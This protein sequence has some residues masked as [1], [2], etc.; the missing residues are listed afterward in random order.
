MDFEVI[1]STIIA[2]GIGTIG[3]AFMIKNLISTGIQKSIELNFNK[4]LETYKSTLSKELENLKSTL[5]NSEVYFVRQLEA[6]SVLRSLFRKILPV[7]QFPDGDWDE[8]LESIVDNFETHRDVLHDYL[9]TYEAVLPTDVRNNL[10]MAYHLVADIRF[11]FE[12]HPDTHEVVPL[13]G[14][15][16]NANSFHEQIRESINRFQH[17]IERQLGHKL[18]STPSGISDS[19]SA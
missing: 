9:C 13:R 18:A 1:S 8:A 14:A 15:M 10:G 6:L 19:D 2:S 3:A 12:S 11:E 4:H 5:K 7:K 16:E 17:E